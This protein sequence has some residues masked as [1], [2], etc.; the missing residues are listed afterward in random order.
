MSIEDY[1]SHSP[2]VKVTIHLCNLPGGT[3]LKLNQAF[4]QK[5]SLRIQEKRRAKSVE[6]LIG[7]LMICRQSIY[8]HINCQTEFTVNSLRSLLKFMKMPFIVTE[9]FIMALGVRKLVHNPRF[10][11]E[12]HTEAG[13]RLRSVLLSEAYL[14]AVPGKSVELKVPELEIHDMMKNDFLNVVGNYPFETL[15]Y[16]WA[17]AYVTRFPAILGSISKL[18]GVPPGDKCSVNPFVPKDIMLGEKR[19]KREYLRWA[20]ASEGTV[21][22]KE[23]SLMRCVDATK[24]LPANFVDGLA[25]GEKIPIGRVP[26]EVLENIRKIPQNLLEGERLLLQD[27]GIDA[28]LGPD[29][30]YKYV[31][32]KRVTTR[33]TLSIARQYDIWRFGESIGFPLRWKNLALTRLVSGFKK[34]GKVRL[35]A[36]DQSFVD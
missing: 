29:C 23:I 3:R 26:K 6:K 12:L 21:K 34:F 35:A 1:V 28:Y 27:F 15:P 22:N 18:A 33:W 16:K 36:S 7:E 19:L 32:T 24:A 5:I 2:D 11:F 13:V 31:T 30:L 25:A 20:F 10:P 17:R 14:P 8:D 9:K 4:H